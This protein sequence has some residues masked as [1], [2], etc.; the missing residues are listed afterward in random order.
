LFQLRDLKNSAATLERFTLADKARAAIA[1]LREIGYEHGSL[2]V[3]VKLTRKT[4]VNI[5]IDV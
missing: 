2:L 4:I 1:S 3:S 5:L